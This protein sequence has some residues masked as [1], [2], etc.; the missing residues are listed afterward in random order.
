MLCMPDIHLYHFRKFSQASDMAFHLR[1]QSLDL[2]LPGIRTIACHIIGS[3]IPCNQKKRCQ[4]Y[5]PRFK[6]IYFFKHRL[7]SRSEFHSTYRVVIMSIFIELSL[8]FFIGVKL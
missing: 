1:P 3:M 7:D 4:E 2:I 5:S 8:Q 6:L